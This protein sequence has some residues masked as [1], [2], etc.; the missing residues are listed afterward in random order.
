MI[1]RRILTLAALAGLL[2]LTRPAVALDPVPEVYQ[3]L[4][5]STWMLPQDA[6]GW[7]LEDLL[8]RLRDPDDKKRHAAMKAIGF[9][10]TRADRTLFWTEIEQPIK[11]ET[12]FL[13]SERRKLAVVTMPVAGRHAWFLVLMVQNAGGEN[14]W[15]PVQFLR[16]DTDPTV[17]LQTSYHDVLG[18]QVFLLRVK[19]LGR[20]DI[21]GTRRLDTI[22]KYDEQRLRQA[23]QETDDFYRPGKFQGEAMRLK[24]D[25]E[26]RGD[27]RIRRSVTVKTYD[28]M[29]GP[30]F[31][32]Y[33]ES[34]VKPKKTETASESFSWNPQNFSFYDP[35]AELQKLRSHKSAWIRSEAARRLGEIL[36]TSAPG[37]EKALLK[38]KNPYV[39][40]QAALALENIGDKAAVGALKQGLAKGAE[41]D[42]V[43]EAMQRA[44][45]SL[46]A[47]SE[48]KKK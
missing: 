28:F 38:D 3:G 22:F 23:Y 39:R 31:F 2:A 8:E 26:F 19:H 21:Y 7:S 30:E 37:L 32:Q 18:D 43:K 6:K 47:K 13:S 33:E 15:R 4:G 10:K 44:L 20:S 11:A 25:L 9:Q 16:F 40:I 36:K 24:Q 35:R 45:D 5:Y 29:K 14:Y 48:K 17:A 1:F 34:G 46:V 42:N 12:R 41:A 27:Q